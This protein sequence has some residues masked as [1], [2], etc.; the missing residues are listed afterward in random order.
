MQKIYQELLKQRSL[1]KFKKPGNSINSNFILMKNIVPGED[2]S[3]VFPE[4]SLCAL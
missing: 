3:Y 2:F 1:T 4:I